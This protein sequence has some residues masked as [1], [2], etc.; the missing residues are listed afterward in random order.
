MKT[1]AILTALMASA[2][3]CSAQ[4]AFGQDFFTHNS[5]PSSFDSRTPGVHCDDHYHTKGKT[6]PGNDS[7]TRLQQQNQISTPKSSK[8]KMVE[9]VV[10]NPYKDRWELRMV[11]E[12]PTKPKRTLSAE[13]IDPGTLKIT[14][15]ITQD[16]NGNLIEEREESWLSDGL[17]NIKITRRQIPI[18]TG[19]ALIEEESRVLRTAGINQN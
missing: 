12:Q 18:S 8:P 3:V 7:E 14:T 5:Q 16:R 15:T 13:K 2:F 11:E 17:A 6:L 1:T 19:N 4:S 9:K 10:F